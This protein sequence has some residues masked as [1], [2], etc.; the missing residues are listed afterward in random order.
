MEKS[1]VFIHDAKNESRLMK[2]FSKKKSHDNKLS[3]K[4]PSY[5]EKAVLETSTE[6]PD[7]FDFNEEFQKAF[8]L[9]ENTQKHL[10][11]TGKA[12][13]GKSTL[14]EYFKLNTK[15]KI[16]VLAP[17]GVASIKIHGQTIHSFFKFPSKFIQK[18]HVRRS[19]N[20]KLFHNLDSIVIDEASMVRADILDG[21]DHSL[22]INTAKYDVPFGG[23]QII[24]FCDL[25]QLSPVVDNEIQ[26]IMEQLYTSPYFFSAH[27]INNIELENVELTKVYRQKDQVFID[28]LNKIRV[29][30]LRQE[31]LKMLNSRVNNNVKQ[32]KGVIVLTTT[33]NDAND[34]NDRHLSELHHKEYKY[35]GQ[36]DGRFDKRSV[37]A[38]ECLS[39]KVGAQVML[40]KNDTEKKWVNGT[41]A[42]IAELSDSV[43][44]V[45]IDGMVYSVPKNTWEKI[46]YKYN[47][48]EGKIEEKVVGAFKQF[49]VKLAWAIT[50][51]KSQGQTFQNVIID[52]GHGAFTHGQTYV[53]LSRCTKLDGIVLKKPINY[54]DIIL[55]DRIY[56]F[57]NR[58][59]FLCMKK[60]DEFNITEPTELS[61]NDKQSIKYK[62]KEYNDFKENMTLN[63][64]SAVCDNKYFSVK[65][66]TD[67][68]RLKYAPDA[69]DE[70]ICC[71]DIHVADDLAK[72]R[73]FKLHKWTHS[74]VEADPKQRKLK[75]LSESILQLKIEGEG[76]DG[77]CRW[78]RTF[79]TGLRTACENDFG[80][81]AFSQDGYCRFEE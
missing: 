20:D 25:F 64:N 6:I 55:D 65:E 1:L 2:S 31:D 36:V 50:I 70:K 24:M 69:Y 23:V 68:V 28:L 17:T 27:V 11:I 39:L 62:K 7:N 5:G 43:I 19:R 4:T 49:P 47:S 37:P 34:I 57:M 77:R 71:F 59:G 13:T 53:A 3:D 29:D 30:Q 56:S 51:H 35:H 21:I 80:S 67:L 12:G 9:M 81:G 48:T 46:E 18:E 15:K 10:F 22:R 79:R 74:K 16:A 76:V 63:E 41:I 52:M 32:K 33:N 73:V 42:E 45:C 78:C 72:E 44:K 40:L 58:S 66:L 61:V 38:Q 8:D 14:L 60:T 75:E 26:N 54:R